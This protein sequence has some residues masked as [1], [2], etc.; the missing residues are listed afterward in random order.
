MGGSTMEGV[1][2]TN[3]CLIGREFLAATQRQ[4]LLISLHRT[5]ALDIELGPRNTYFFT[6]SWRAGSRGPLEG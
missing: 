2:T 4:E 1:P 6:C 3:A 5:R